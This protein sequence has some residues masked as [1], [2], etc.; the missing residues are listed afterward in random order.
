M[1]SLPTFLTLAKSLQKI[2]T[3]SLDFSPLPNLRAA[4]DV[5][6]ELPVCKALSCMMWFQALSL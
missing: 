1:K 4:A 2:Y 3:F 6:P 5:S